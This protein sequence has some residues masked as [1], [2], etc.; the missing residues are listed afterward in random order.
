MLRSNSVEFSSFKVVLLGG[1]SVGKSWLLHRC[2]HGLIDQRIPSTIGISFSVKRV[3]LEDDTQV[4]L[5]IWDTAGAARFDSLSSAQCEGAHAI[6]V[7][8][9]ITEETSFERAKKWVKEVQEMA[10]PNIFLALVGNKADLEA[11]RKIK[12][13]DAQSY[14]ESIGIDLCMELSAKSGGN[15]EELLLA[16]GYNLKLAHMSV[17]DLKE[18]IDK[19]S[20][21]LDLGRRKLVRVPDSVAELR[22]VQILNL[23]ENDLTQLPRCLNNL[24]NAT[25]LILSQNKL[26]R[27][28]DAIIELTNL[29]CLNVSDNQ[30][31][32]LPKAII[33]L[34]KLQVLDLRNNK[35]QRLDADISCLKRLKKLSVNGNPLELEA[36][37]S[38]MDLKEKYQGRICLDIAGS[39]KKMQISLL[40]ISF[41]TDL[42]ST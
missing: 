15:M 25:M 35:L 3:N 6:I 38:L 21:T 23:S 41:K 17:N 30:I 24:K 34:Q 31:S 39:C 26:K 40:A 7:V 1:N 18:T 27:L 22:E 42:I 2:I 11:N 36:V 19:N 20:K 32:C 29:I 13:E 9:D 4:K 14:A 10:I 5:V 37:R 8:Y 28:P 33:S 16:I 12:S